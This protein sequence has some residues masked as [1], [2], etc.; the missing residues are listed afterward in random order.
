MSFLSIAKP[1]C[2]F[3]SRTQAALVMAGYRLARPESWP[4]GLSGDLPQGFGGLAG[5]PRST[6]KIIEETRWTRTGVR[7]LGS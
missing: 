5:V 6:N 2:M 4:L 1:S 7:R 3:T